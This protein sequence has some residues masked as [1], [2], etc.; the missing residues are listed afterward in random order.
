MRR[1]R[2]CEVRRT[3][4]SALA[5]LLALPVCGNA[6]AGHMRGSHR[7]ELSSGAVNAS[8]TLF[9]PVAARQLL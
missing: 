4:P 8:G 6:T 5:G 1:S 3:S 7:R 2:N 9:A